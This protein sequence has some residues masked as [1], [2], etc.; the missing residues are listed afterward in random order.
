MCGVPVGIAGCIFEDQEVHVGYYG[1]MAGAA[2]NFIGTLV[3]YSGNK[4]EYQHASN[5]ISALEL[6][7]KDN[8]FLSLTKKQENKSMIEEIRDD[9]RAFMKEHKSII[10]WTLILYV[11]D[12]YCFEGALKTRLQK[13]VHNL[14]GKVEE[15]LDK[16]NL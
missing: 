16:A 5:Q 14:V 8:P 10:Y 12:H 2:S 1:G 9:I 11:V 4:P 6:E 15:K 13:M 7:Y 3:Q